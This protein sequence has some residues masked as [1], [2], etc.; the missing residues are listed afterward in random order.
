MAT[1]ASEGKDGDALQVHQERDLSF[2]WVCHG[3]IDLQVREALQASQC[4]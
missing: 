4:S 2:S 1:F 3:C